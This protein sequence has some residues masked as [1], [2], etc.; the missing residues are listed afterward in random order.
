MIR[1]L[2]TLALTILI[3]PLI[4]QDIPKF[5]RKTSAQIQ[6][7]VVDG[8]IRQSSAAYQYTFIGNYQAALDHYELHLDWRLDSLTPRDSLEL[9]TFRATDAFDYLAE[10]TKEEEIVIISE[11]HHKPQHRVFTTQLLEQL[12]ANGFR[13]L[14]LECLTNN[15]V[16]S[17]LFLMDTELNERGYPMDSPITG[18]YAQEPQMGQLI[19]KAL[20]LGFELFAYERTQK[21]IERDLQQALNIQRFLQQQQEKSPGK[22]IGKVVIHCGWY[23]AIE[24][25]FPKRQSDHYMAYHLKQLTGIDPLT[26]YQDA[27]SEKSLFPAS[28]YYELIEAKEI[29][30]LINPKNEVY[31][32]PARMDHFDVLI[33]HPP[34]RMINGR[35]HWIAENPALIAHELQ[36]MPRMDYPILAKAYDYGEDIKKATPIDVIEV[37]NNDVP[38]VF[39]LPKGMYLIEVN[40]TFPYKYTWEIK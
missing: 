27:L 13:Y 25:A 40:G 11:A 2:I 24:S 26:I 37:A 8:S 32:G 1:I 17:N 16:D 12:Y 9:L 31:Q 34:T 4:A 10:R 19:R 38:R 18:Y 30:I 39:Y 28:P 15:P 14:G 23:H 5:H 6:K 35:P 7:G 21:G 36:L 20:E 22:E 29:S 3:I 33:Y